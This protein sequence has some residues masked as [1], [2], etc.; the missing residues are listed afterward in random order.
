[1]LREKRSCHAYEPEK[2]LRKRALHVNGSKRACL[3]AQL[4]LVLPSLAD[5]APS[6]D[7]L[8]R[9]STEIAVLTRARGTEF[10][11]FRK[12]EE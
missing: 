12:R 1:M 11:A 9:T 8:K 6:P 5:S 7:L 4:A 3:N 10:S 2:H